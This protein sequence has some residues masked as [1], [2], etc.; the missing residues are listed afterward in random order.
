MQFCKQTR[1]LFSARHSMEICFHALTGLAFVWV[2][3]CAKHCVDSTLQINSICK[4]YWGYGW[5]LLRFPILIC[6]YK[7]IHVDSILYHSDYR[8]IWLVLNFISRVFEKFVFFSRLN[9]S[10]L[11][12]VCCEVRLVLIIDFI[13]WFHF[14]VNTIQTSKSL[15]AANFFFIIDDQFDEKVK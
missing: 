15:L 5:V 2:C 1:S 3:L 14:L 11:L 13:D 9:S 12:L 7:A 6:L 10:F 4:F 8:F